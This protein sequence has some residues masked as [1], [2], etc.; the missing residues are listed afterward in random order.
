MY[1]LLGAILVIISNV[2][3]AYAYY[4]QAAKANLEEDSTQISSSAYKI[5]MIKY[6]VMIVGLFIW[7]NW[8]A[9]ISEIF[10]LTCCQLSLLWVMQFKPKGWEL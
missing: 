8:I 5:K 3:E 1:K 10:A 7:G 6:L 2:C 4:K 9:V